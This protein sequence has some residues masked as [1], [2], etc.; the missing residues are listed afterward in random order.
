MWDFGT[1]SVIATFDD[2]L[3]KC[4]SL[5]FS[6]SGDCVYSASRY[7]AGAVWRCDLRTRETTLLFRESEEKTLPHDV[8]PGIYR[9]AIAPDDGTLQSFV[10]TARSYSTSPQ[11]QPSSLSHMGAGRR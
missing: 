1:E 6:P 11:N 10:V 4:S 3:G 8:V 7:P 9:L 2:D 5:V